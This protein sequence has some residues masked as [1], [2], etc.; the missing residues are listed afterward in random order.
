MDKKRD[1]ISQRKYVAEIKSLIQNKDPNILDGMHLE[2][3][4]HNLRLYK[5]QRYNLIKMK[6]SARRR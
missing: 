6:R 1:L 4:N 3:Y 5:K 2:I